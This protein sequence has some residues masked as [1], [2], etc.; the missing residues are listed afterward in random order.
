MMRKRAS[1]TLDS[2]RNLKKKVK[3]RMRMRKRASG[4]LDSRSGLKEKH[5]LTEQLSMS[6]EEAPLW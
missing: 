3:T 1:G 2:K 5:R 6:M 4:I